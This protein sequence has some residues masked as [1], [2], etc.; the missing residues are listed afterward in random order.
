MGTDYKIS[1]YDSISSINKEKYNA[2]VDTENPFLEYEFLDARFGT[3]TTSLCGQNAVQV[4]NPEGR[5]VSLEKLAAH[6]RP[7]GEV[8]Y[9]DFMLSFKENGHEIVVFPDGRAIVKNTDDEALA[10]GLFARYIGT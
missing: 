7:L 6:L 5:E 3:R 10:K 9:N 4:L 8:S 1:V 2:I